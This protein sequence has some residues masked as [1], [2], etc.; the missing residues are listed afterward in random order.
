MGLEYADEKFSN[1]VHVLA[2]HRAAI[3]ERLVAALRGGVSSVQMERDVPEGLHDEYRKFLERITSGSP[4]SSE[5]SLAASVREMS[6]DEAVEVASL[7][8]Q[9]EYEFRVR[10]EEERKGSSQ[11]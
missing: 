10:L 6:E 8:M 7:I 5:G 2:T 9:F 1:A 4:V 3:K 11:R